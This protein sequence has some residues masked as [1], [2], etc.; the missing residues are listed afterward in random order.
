MGV[1]QPKGEVETREDSKSHP[2][3]KVNSDKM[4]TDATW[5][6]KF[7]DV[8]L[9]KD[10]RKKAKV[11]FSRTINLVLSVKSQIHDS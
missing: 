5:H 10:K 6:I 8:V 1:G 4:S 7:N 2:K 3:I 9:D 11:V